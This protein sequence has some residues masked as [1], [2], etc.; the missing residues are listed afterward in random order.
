MF[1][2]KLDCCGVCVRTRGVT[3]P[4]VESKMRRPQLIVDALI[5]MRWWII[6]IADTT[7]PQ[8]FSRALNSIRCP[9]SSLEDRD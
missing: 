2:D 3:S 9:I 6:L 7:S 8:S 4:C 1:F 5:L